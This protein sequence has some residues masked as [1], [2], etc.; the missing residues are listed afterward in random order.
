MNEL[1]GFSQTA[2]FTQNWQIK[3]YFRGIFWCI[4]LI[5]ERGDLRGHFSVMF[6]CGPKC[7]KKPTRIQLAAMENMYFILHVYMSICL[8]TDGG[9]SPQGEQ[10]ADKALCPQTELTQGGKWT[11]T[12]MYVF[13]HISSISVACSRPVG[14]P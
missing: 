4:N 10:C 8:L 9:R 5:C 12:F 7:C 1:S 2:P 6:A 11:Y 14:V 3:V 13:I